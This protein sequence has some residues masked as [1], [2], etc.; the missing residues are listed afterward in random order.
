MIFITTHI[1]REVTCTLNTAHL[2]LF[3]KNAFDPS[4][5]QSIRCF[6]VDRSPGCN[7]TPSSCLHQVWFLRTCSFSLSL[8]FFQILASVRDWGRLAII[9]IETVSKWRL[10]MPYLWKWEAVDPKPKVSG[11]SQAVELEARQPSMG[12]SRIWPGS[13]V[14]EIQ[15]P[16]F[17]PEG[18]KSHTTGEWVTLNHSNYDVGFCSGVWPFT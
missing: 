6:T 4:S 14:P 8:Y 3:I 16:L 5:K 2:L 18:G 13:R 15:H 17:L 7:Q 1:D 12:K 10:P 11:L 9:Q